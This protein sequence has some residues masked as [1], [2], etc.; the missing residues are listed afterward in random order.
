MRE[1]RNAS[2]RAPTSASGTVKVTEDS[3]SEFK[4]SGMDY[5]LHG[6]MAAFVF[7]RS[8][9]NL[10]ASASINSPFTTNA[11]S[12]KTSPLELHFAGSRKMFH[13][14][15]HLRVSPVSCRYA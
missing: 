6:V 3:G 14:E 7:R 12:V 10:S 8:A 11:F 15:P 1:A 9:M 4:F 2:S 13:G 5:G